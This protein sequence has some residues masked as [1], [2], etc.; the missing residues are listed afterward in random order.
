MDTDQLLIGQFF[1]DH[2]SLAVNYIESLDVNKI[3]SL[4]EILTLDQNAKLFSKMNAFKAGQVLEKISITMACAIIDRLSILAAQSLL[5]VVEKS[6]REVILNQMKPEEAIPLR[7][8]L[9]Y[10]VERVG[11]HIDPFVLTL[12]GQMTIK[13][14]LEAIHSSSADA[15][16]HIFILDK[17]KKLTGY[18]EL[19]DLLQGEPHLQIKTKQSLVKQPALAD[20]SVADLLDHWDH[21]LVYLPVIDVN[22]VFIGS[23]SRAV[24]SQIHERR[25][26][27]KSTDHAAI[28]AGN[29]LGDLFMIGLTSLLG[30][31]AD[32][33]NNA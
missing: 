2:E 1:K 22:G 5:R 11:A 12:S 19:Y 16:P 9:T 27:G 20:M 6:K 13:K 3:A 18:V 24:L 29:A 15:Q 28:K 32:S 33:D 14:G 7:R 4:V 21:T 17:D 25:T 31:S 10:S 23:A 8:G 30:S 26:S